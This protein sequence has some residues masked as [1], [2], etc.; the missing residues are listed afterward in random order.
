MKRRL[1]KVV[2]VSMVV[3]VLIGAQPASAQ[4]SIT[5]L[6][7]LG[8]GDCSLPGREFSQANGINDRGQVVGGSSTDG[9]SIH[10][11][12]WEKGKMTDLG[13]LPGGDFSQARGVNNRGQ[14][15]G[16]SD[17]ASGAVHAV[18]WTK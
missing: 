17:T 18:L 2:L 1:G 13:A 8:G 15:V 11:F 14:V 5:D 16:G 7:T 4:L 6:G 12:L 3:A 9:C 10:A